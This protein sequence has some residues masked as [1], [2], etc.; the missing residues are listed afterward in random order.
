MKFVTLIV[1]ASLVSCSFLEKRRSHFSYAK[2]GLKLE[3]VRE[4][5]GEPKNESFDQDETILTYDYCKTSY[6]KEA[7]GGL[8]TFTTYNW[9]CNNQKSFYHMY[10]KN[11]VLY[12]SEDGTS[13]Y[14]R[15]HR[16][17]Q[18]FQDKGSQTKI[19]QAAS[20]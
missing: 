5:S 19:P 6:L 3:E 12:R 7:V 14:E 1:L 18:A 11:G 9:H 10:F 20:N 16:K 8:L 13:I 4:K 15:V 2:P 17:E